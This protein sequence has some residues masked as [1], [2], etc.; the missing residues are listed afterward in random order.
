MW[1]FVKERDRPA[2]EDN[3]ARQNIQVER[4]RPS[5]SNFF[6]SRPSSSAASVHGANSGGIS[7]FD[8]RDKEKAAGKEKASKEN[9]RGMPLDSEEFWNNQATGRYRVHRKN[10]PC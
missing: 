2:H 4:E 9:W 5:I 6:G 3:H 10:T 7:F 1:T 8:G